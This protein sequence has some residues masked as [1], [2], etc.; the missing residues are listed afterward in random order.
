MHRARLNNIAEVIEICPGDLSESARRTMAAQLREASAAMQADA[1]ALA[2]VRTLDAYYAKEQ[3]DEPLAP[4][5][6]D[7]G[8]WVVLC[9]G[10]PVGWGPTP[11]AARALAAAWVREQAK[12][13]K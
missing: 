8:S 4:H 12:G 2:D 11:D 9:A 6:N 7:S 3:L 1:Q 13:A 5:I 10:T